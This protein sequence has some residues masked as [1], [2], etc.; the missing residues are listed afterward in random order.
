MKFT[1]IL[2]LT[3]MFSS[4]GV[5][6]DA[7]S[8]LAAF[9]AKMNAKT[10]QELWDIATNVT[11]VKGA[12]GNN[13]YQTG[14][15]SCYISDARNC[16]S[17]A[18][19]YYVQGHYVKALGS[20]GIKGWPKNPSSGDST[21]CVSS[22]CWGG[23]TAAMCGAGSDV[24]HAAAQLR[25]AINNTTKDPCDLVTYVPTLRVS[26]KHGLR[27]TDNVYFTD[28][29]VTKSTIRCATGELNNPR[30]INGQSVKHFVEL[31]TPFCNRA[32][33]T[34][35]KM[36]TVN[37][38][39]ILTASDFTNSINNSQL[40]VSV[41]PID[42]NALIMHFDIAHAY[43]HLFNGISLVK[44][45]SGNFIDLPK[46]KTLKYY[47]GIWGKTLD[48]NHPLKAAVDS[49]GTVSSADVP[50][51]LLTAVSYS[52]ARVTDILATDIAVFNTFGSSSIPLAANR[53]IAGLADLQ[54]MQST[55]VS[56][57]ANMQYTYP[58]YSQIQTI[59]APA[60][61][62]PLGGN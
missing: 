55:F 13:H 25:D 48:A 31:P 9:K 61:V 44:D 18:C 43:P 3:L 22:T 56:A 51:G 17:C 4:Q 59:M 27:V 26:N 15:G 38:N 11:I 60:Q 8:D 24:A 53:N 54:T 5:L 6:A 28:P 57:T 16:S 33:R 19:D 47:L 42:I 46:I 62:A 39:N 20:L 36:N 12:D 14:L 10:D 37:V 30:I 52:Q 45:N 41:K 58:S 40:I 1:G 23:Y 29:A 49:V 35:K 50:S 34:Q 21:G 7:A 32:W 2:M